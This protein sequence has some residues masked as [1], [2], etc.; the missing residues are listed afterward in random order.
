MTAVI[1]RKRVMQFDFLSDA[2][3]TFEWN[4]VYDNMCVFCLSFKR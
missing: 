4:E 2:C 1:F 3:P